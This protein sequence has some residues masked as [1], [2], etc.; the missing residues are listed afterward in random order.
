MGRK[1]RGFASLASLASL[2]ALASLASLASEKVIARSPRPSRPFVTP[3]GS[4]IA[5]GERGT[6]WTLPGRV[7]PPLTRPPPGS[8][9]LVR[10][11]NRAC[12]W[13][14]GG[15]GESRSPKPPASLAARRSSRRDVRTISS[16]PR[17]LEHACI[18]HQHVFRTHA[19]AFR[20][21]A[22]AATAAMLSS[23][24]CHQ[25]TLGARTPT[26]CCL[27]CLVHTPASPPEGRAA[28]PALRSQGSA[29]SQ[30]SNLHICTLLLYGRSPMRAFSRMSFLIFGYS[31][32]ALMTLWQTSTAS[33][34]RLAL[35]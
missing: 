13:V 19:A 7:R 29:V 2:A 30:P 15:M 3:H 27:P 12:W 26:S 25:A 6:H 10:G 11:I 4:S 28:G 33:T 5:P 16:R 8:Y 17:G 22:A 32:N 21:H 9:Q 24:S 35:R 18:Q 34:K 31:G 14:V 23:A 1:R 20:T